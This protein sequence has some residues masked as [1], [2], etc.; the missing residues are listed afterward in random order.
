MGHMSK[1]VVLL[2]LQFYTYLL[3]QYTS[4]QG[5]CLYCDMTGSSIMSYGYTVSDIMQK[6]SLTLKTGLLQLST[7]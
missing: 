6:T 3:I 5:K 4:R 1:T 7:H 2:W